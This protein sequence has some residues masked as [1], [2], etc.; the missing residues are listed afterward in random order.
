V[1]YFEDVVFLED[2]TV[3]SAT[4]NFGNGRVDRISEKL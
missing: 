2:V 3:E 4:I 1:W